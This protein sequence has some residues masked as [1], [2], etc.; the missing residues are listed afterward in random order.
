MDNCSRLQLDFKPTNNAV[1]NFYSHFR[2]ARRGGAEVVRIFKMLL[3]ER[4]QDVFKRWLLPKLE[5]MYVG[6]PLSLSH[7]LEINK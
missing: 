4:D 5:N 2:I 7:I 6:A 1:V 3:Q